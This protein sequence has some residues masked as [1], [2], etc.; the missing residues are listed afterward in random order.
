[1]SLTYRIKIEMHLTRHLSHF[2]NIFIIC[3][4]VF[5]QYSKAV[6][7]AV[8][9]I[10][11][12]SHTEFSLGK[13]LRDSSVSAMP[14]HRIV[15]NINLNYLL[16]R[17]VVR[18]RTGAEVARIETI[19]VIPDRSSLATR[20]AT[21][22]RIKGVLFLNSK[23]NGSTP[24]TSGRWSKDQVS[25]AMASVRN[26]L[27]V[28]I[29]PIVGQQ[30]VG[31]VPEDQTKLFSDLQNEL[32]TILQLGLPSG[33]KLQVQSD[34]K[35]KL[36]RLRREAPEDDSSGARKK[37]FSGY[38]MFL[39]KT[40]KT[41]MLCPYVIEKDVNEQRFP[42]TINRIKCKFENC[43]CSNKGSFRCTQLWTKYEVQFKGSVGTDEV[44]VEHSC[45]CA[46]SQSVNAHDIEL[47]GN[48]V[49]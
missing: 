17:Q 43:L 6:P 28:N 14:N 47:P 7:L 12:K 48:L 15:E 1:M 45:V 35:G 4:L 30:I 16:R 39:D 27:G 37:R 41:S 42:K 22:N 26:L 36:F 18:N 5:V 8:K 19:R 44:D 23:R 21:R 31:Q 11:L 9:Q 29:S 32:L 24:T 49:S 20:H 40:E 34:K 10:N 25:R 13:K 46:T 38:K 3:C 33:P 2:I